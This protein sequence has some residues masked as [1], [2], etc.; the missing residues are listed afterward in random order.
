MLLATAGIGT[1]WL[2]GIGSLALPHHDLL[3]VLG[4]VGLMGGAV[5]LV[6]MQRRA[7]RCGGTGGGAPR[8]LR[9]ALLAGLVS[10]AV[11]LYLGYSYV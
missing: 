2:G 7:L 11:L 10:G 6:L 3:L 4:V 1:A 8:W 5:Q 9:L